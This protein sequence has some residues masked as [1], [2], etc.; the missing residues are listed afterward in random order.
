VLAIRICNG[1]TAALTHMVNLCPVAWERSCWRRRKETHLQ[2]C[3][4]KDGGKVQ[5]QWAW[6][7]GSH[8]CRTWG[9]LGWLKKKNKTKKTPV[10]FYFLQNHRYSIQDGNVLFCKTLS[11]IRRLGSKEGW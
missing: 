4:R 10:C 2:S 11:E 7:R 5:A 1:R 8:A 3:R 6:E 9:V